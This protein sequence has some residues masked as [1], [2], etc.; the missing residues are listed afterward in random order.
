MFDQWLNDIIQADQGGLQITAEF[1]AEFV[2]RSWTE[3]VNN[4]DLRWYLSFTS[5]EVTW[6]STTLARPTRFPE[7]GYYEFTSDLAGLD[8]EDDRTLC[9]MNLSGPLAQDSRVQWVLDAL[10]VLGA[11]LCIT[12]IM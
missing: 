9:L 8:V 1:G 4:P 7:T 2:G 12:Q 5:P 11:D 10:N 3:I 6:G